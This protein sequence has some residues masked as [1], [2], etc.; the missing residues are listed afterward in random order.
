MAPPTP[1][2]PPPPLPGLAPGP[3]T[4]PE[5]PNAA[6]ADP[7]IDEL[8][9]LIRQERDP[10][11]RAGAVDRYVEQ[12]GDP[13]FRRDAWFLPDEPLLGFVEI[14]A[15]LFL[16]GSDTERDSGAFADETPQHEVTLPSYYIARY[17]VTVAQF[18]VFVGDGGG[19]SN[20]PE[21]LRGQAS[22]PVTHVTWHEAVGYCR[23]LTAK[24]G[25][26]KEAP[27]DLRRLL[28]GDG[29][30][31]MWRVTLP[32]EAEWEKAARGTDS[33]IYPWGNEIGANLANYD[34]T[35]ISRT[36]AVGCFPGGVSPF[37]VEELSGNVWEWTR[38]L[39]GHYPYGPSQKRE[40]LAIGD[41]VPR[42]LR[43]GSFD[44][45]GGGVRAAL[46]YGSRPDGRGDGSGFRV[47]V[48]PFSP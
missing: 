6:P 17:P 29:V 3:Q 38:S 33:R 4:H 1:E 31:R 46:R 15:G 20:D 40:D 44:S 43:G 12:H 13:R 28:R 5:V 16:M 47:V 36:T 21:S 41:D 19:T 32:S 37:G 45:D 48:S 22:H 9:A 18:R 24:L 10:A 26:S 35:N 2:P 25:A 39:Q 27:A 14:P 42:V 7:R 30:E 34:D 23:W 8:A 11:A